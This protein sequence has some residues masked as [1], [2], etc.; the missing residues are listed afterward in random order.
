MYIKKSGDIKILMVFIELDYGGL[1]F[2][3]L[4]IFVMF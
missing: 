1:L 4:Y 3:N 2:G